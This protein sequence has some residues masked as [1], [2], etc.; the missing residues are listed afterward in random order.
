MV[1]YDNLI[2]KEGRFSIETNSDSYSRKLAN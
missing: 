1:G 2:V